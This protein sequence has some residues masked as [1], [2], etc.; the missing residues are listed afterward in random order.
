MTPHQKIVV[1]D[2]NTPMKEMLE[3]LGIQVRKLPT[4]LRCPVHKMGT[5]S[6]PSA[7]IYE[8]NRFVWCFTCLKQY[9]ASEIYSVWRNVTR[10]E[11]ANQL[12][13]KWPASES[14]IA[15]ILKDYTTPKRKEPDKAII[16][17]LENQLLRF[18][19]RVSLEKY[20]KWAKEVDYFPLFLASLDPKDRK[21]ALISF[22]RRM[23]H[24]L[25]PKDP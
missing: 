5:E 6:K 20:R 23:E 7:K 18:K 21:I 15:T 2:G 10:A 3:S 16:D 22:L 11:A 25:E 4:Q 12:L 14:S 9:Q 17:Y 19:R 24:D 8:D 1:A 13:M